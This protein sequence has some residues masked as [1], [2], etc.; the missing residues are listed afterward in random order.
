MH[1]TE[2]NLIED[3]SLETILAKKLNFNIKICK[4]Y[5]IEIF[6]VKTG[7]LPENILEFIEK[8]LPANKSVIQARGS[9]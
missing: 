6:K 4:K 9:K 2:L 1:N 3:Y 5:V 7:L 8:P